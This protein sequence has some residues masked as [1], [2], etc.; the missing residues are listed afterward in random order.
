VADEKDETKLMPC[1]E[2]GSPTGVIELAS[3]SHPWA[4]HCQSENEESEYYRVVGYCTYYKDHS[5]TPAE[6]T[7]KH[8]NAFAWK[9]ARQ[10]AEALSLGSSILFDS[11]SG[12]IAPLMEKFQK[13]APEALAAARDAGV[14]D[15]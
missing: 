13:S 10:L 12:A 2:C 1:L 7:G 8:N 9:L 11:A 5:A 15:K 3:S 4:I 6:A 14:L